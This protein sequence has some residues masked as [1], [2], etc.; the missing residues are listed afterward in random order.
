MTGAAVLTVSW[1][2]WGAVTAVFVAL[3]IWKSL[4]GLKEENIVVL[5]PAEDKQA[6][7]QQAIVAKVQRVTAWAKGFGFASGA[8]LLLAGSVWAYRGYLAFTGGQIP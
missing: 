2:A 8:L 6:A 3:M 1:M 7:E 4:V 5:D